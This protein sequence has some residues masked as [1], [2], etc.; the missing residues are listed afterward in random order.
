[1][2]LGRC[3]SRVALLVVLAMVGTPLA[4]SARQ[5]GGGGRSRAGSGGRVEDPDAFSGPTTIDNP[6]FPLTPGTQF[7]FEGTANR[8]GGGG[9][10]EVIFTV[11]DVT[12]EING[13]RTVAV[14]DRDIQDGELVEEELAFFAQ[15]DGG[16]VWN[17]GEYPEEY[18]DG[19]FVGAP[20]T[21]LDG[22]NDAE[23]GIHMLADPHVGDSYT[24]G[25][26]PDIEF[27]DVAEVIRKSNRRTCVPEGC[28]RPT[29]VTEESSPL[30]P[31]GGTQQKFHARGVGIVKIT[32]QDDIEA[33]TLELV[34]LNQ[35]DEDEMAEATDA[36]LALDERAYDEAEDVWEDTEPAEASSDQPAADEPSADEPASDEPSH[37]EPDFRGGGLLSGL[38]GGDG[39]FGDDGRFGLLSGLLAGRF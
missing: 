2:G 38:F 16:T 39:L 19:E 32:A 1:M 31:A 30:D 33:E 8:G 26:A 7:V 20:S 15:D 23:R 36:A 9:A 34:E 13:V 37:H 25:S 5:N 24:Q 27:L 29:L 35:L 22:V 11:T 10:H 12:K 14:W 28:F 4:A 18:E 17:L 21:W 3:S 6:W